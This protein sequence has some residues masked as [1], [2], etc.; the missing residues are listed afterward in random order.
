MV[1]FGGALALSFCLIGI[2]GA[3]SASAQDGCYT[4]RWP[5]GSFS[6]ECPSTAP[7]AVPPPPRQQPRYV[8]PNYG[9]QA[10]TSIPKVV[11]PPILQCYYGPFNYVPNAPGCYLYR[12]Y[13]GYVY[14][15]CC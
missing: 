4:K 10:Y 9:G 2:S 14:A 7:R 1:R 15:R 3:S 13:D 8:P 6:T 5:D 11:V 12:G